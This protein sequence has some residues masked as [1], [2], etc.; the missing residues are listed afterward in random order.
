MYGNLR[1]AKRESLIAPHDQ[2]SVYRQDQR[3]VPLSRIPSLLPYLP[4]V[5]RHHTM[6]R[7]RPHNIKRA[8][9]TTARVEGILGIRKEDPARTYERRAPLCPDSVK[10]LVR[11]GHVVLVEKSGKRI[12]RDQ[13]YERVESPLR[14]PIPELSDSSLFSIGWSQTSRRIRLYS[15]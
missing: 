12:Y 6:L 8:L 10:D 1:L 5:S 14:K 2:K 15:M 9:H 4:H 13:A 7:L 11:E 3:V